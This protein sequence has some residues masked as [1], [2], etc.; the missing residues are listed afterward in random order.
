M[1]LGAVAAVIVTAGATA[2]SPAAVATRE[3]VLAV[4]TQIDDAM[5]ANDPV[6]LARHLTDDATRTGPSGELTRRT[7]WLAQIASGAIRY[8]AVRRSEPDIRLYGDVAVVTGVVAIDVMK[9][10]LGKVEE[11]NRYLRV[12][13][14][15]GGR[16]LLAAHQATAVTP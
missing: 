2:A 13:L 11:R 3:A 6:A 12:Y 14:R 10:G 1:G 16:W 5:L 9:P 4:Q 15:R 8:L 7:E